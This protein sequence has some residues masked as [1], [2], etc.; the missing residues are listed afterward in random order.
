MSKHTADQEI[1]Q[2]QIAAECR[3]EKKANEQK[4]PQQG[5][6]VKRLT[7]GSQSIFLK[8]GDHKSR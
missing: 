2:S 6:I 5:H 8:W 1:Q 4:H 3:T 7:K